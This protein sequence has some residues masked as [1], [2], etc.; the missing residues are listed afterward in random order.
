M[1]QNGSGKTTIIEC[2]RYATTGDLPPNSKGGA[3]IHDPKICGEN[4]V[5]GQVKLAFTN[6]N[7]VDMICT[8]T[9]QL[10][11]KK[12]TR[13]FKTLEGQLMASNNGERTTISTRCAELD[14]QMPLYLGVPKSILDYVVFCHQEDSLWPL[15]EPS[16]L[17]KRFD[18]I[19][20]A[21][22][23][24]KALDSIKT[25]RKE[26]AVEIKLQKQTTEYLRTDK[27]RADRA[28]ERAN[29]LIEKIEDYNSEA[30]VLERKMESVTGQ[31]DEL[32]KTNQQFQQVLAE[33]AQLKR[34]R[35]V[36]GEQRERLEKSCT[37]LLAV[38]DAELEQQV[39]QFDER[40]DERRAEVAR[41]KT[42][43]ES[44]RQVMETSRNSYND[45]IVEVGQ[46]EA[47]EKER[48]R[49][50]LEKGELLGRIGQS[51]GLSTAG[52]VE[53]ELSGHLDSLK[54]KLEKTK[55]EAG[56]QESAQNDKI[57]RLQ[58]S[59]TE[60]R[61]Q[62]SHDKASVQGYESEVR[63]L[64][65]EVD[66]IPTVEGTIAYEESVIG[67]LSEQLVALEGSSQSSGARLESDI[68]ACDEDLESMSKR[69][70]RCNSE[71]AE[72]NSKS[73]KRAELRMLVSEVSR[74][75]GVLRGLE[76]A[77]RGDLAS[78]G[79]AD[80]Q[81]Y[82]EALASAAKT[83]ETSRTAVES[84][85]KSLSGLETRFDMLNKES[86]VKD[87]TL[88]DLYETISAVLG[89][90]E[91]NID[92]YENTVENLNNDLAVA[93]QNR[94]STSFT[95]K[96][97]E[98][99]VK[100][101]KSAQHSCLLCTRK[102]GD[103][104]LDMFLTHVQQKT[105]SLPDTKEKAD[106]DYEE[107][108]ADVD[109]AQSI[110]GEVR[111]WRA[112]NSSADKVSS[113]LKR[114]KQEVKDTKEELERA[115]ETLSTSESALRELERLRK[116]IDDVSRQKTEVEGKE[117]ELKQFEQ[118]NGSIDE[119]EG[120]NEDL[121]GLASSLNAQ[122]RQLNQ[123]RQKLV[124]ERESLRNQMSSL[125]GQI[126]DKK[127]GLSTQKNQLTLKAGLQQQITALKAKIDVCRDRIRAVRDEVEGMS[128][129]LESLK[130]ELREMKQRTLDETTRV[131][132]ELQAVQ[133]D[134]NK[135]QFVTSQISQLEA[136]DI[137]GKMKSAQT[138][139]KSSKSKVDSL[140]E[141]IA[142][143][144]ESI[145]AQEKALIDLKGHQRNL[146][147]NL[148]VRRL[149]REM[150][151][152]ATRVA[153]LD[154]AKAT[155]ERDE[156]QNE[157]QKL[158][159]KHTQYSSK[160]AGL[161]GEVKQ[162]DGQLSTLNEELQSEF[163]GVHE[164]YRKALITLKTTTVAN[165]DLAKY[166]NALDSAIMQYHSMKMNEINAI[167]DEL[168]KSTYSGTDID[169]ILIRSESDKPATASKTAAA[170]SVNRSYNYRV[171]MV[172]SD[173]EL[174]MRGRCSA[175]QKVL[176]SIIIRLALAECFGINCGLIALDEPTTN[177]DS[178]NIESLARSLGN[179]I[180]ARSSQKN[181]QLI[182]ITHDE[183]FLTHMAASEHTD[184]FYRVSRNIRQ[185]SSIEWCPITQ[186]QE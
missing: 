77:A 173:A 54:S 48:G 33:V 10:L 73:E 2:L 90:G 70:E 140:A 137:V 127:L 134:S 104:E 51:Y 177:L 43:A 24:T 168:W 147:D 121:P 172:K 14:A 96:Y 105:E 169:T 109:S 26:K 3:F 143:L 123:K 178:D 126:S 110:A 39:A 50:E 141:E 108:K 68:S 65:D 55:R 40:L 18:E 22:K 44:T 53:A 38:P 165:D 157:A 182:V 31:S 8:R 129:R 89:E 69:L 142:T 34:D 175:G 107:I 21:L 67:Q 158:R 116:V 84:S 58:T 64:Q 94:E 180:G 179:I 106:N 60:K 118:K 17:K 75:Q 115:E 19:F 167:I 111:E 144:Q 13:Q 133:N 86:I 145:A 20:Q 82:A 91:D 166:S 99:A 71:L 9:M 59:L 46:W 101:A 95:A 35:V 150:E 128:P 112:L 153:A 74:G 138:R 57:E 131:S 5:L 162:M 87:A 155:R 100:L 183:K 136:L 92:D 76:E 113:E 176:A 30:G 11:V 161:M 81:G 25:L 184:H 117:A 15:S 164:R 124:D 148:E 63:R 28:T 72:F 93:T 97:Y 23:F 102:F 154:E 163:L 85:R 66:T 170:S 186:I 120:S 151:A 49:Q 7:G 42:E 125:Q 139:S 41:L 130:S 122:I 29:A 16:V 159:Q 171:C 152:I 80:V 181:F 1:G 135:L 114:V 103:S 56:T 47:K 119:S 132:D 174:D 78:A 156:Y 98:T 32:F 160:H 61:G 4:E 62:I 6:V 146:Q 83:V 88:A 79:V 149:S 37:E 185:K 45:A 12:T 27:E 52:D 36:V